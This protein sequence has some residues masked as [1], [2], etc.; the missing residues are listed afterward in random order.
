MENLR[1]KKTHF[2]AKEEKNEKINEDKRKK[3][4]HL[5]A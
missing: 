5:G 3:F 1:K 4:F 2:I